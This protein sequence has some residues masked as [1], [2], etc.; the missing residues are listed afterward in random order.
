MIDNLY[1]ELEQKLAVRTVLHL[2]N[3]LRPCLAKAVKKKL[4][5]SNPA[6]DAD[7]P[8]PEDKN[9]A[10]VLDEDQLAALVRGFRGH[11][12]EMIVDVGANTGARRNEIIALCWSDLDLDKK[13]MTITRSVEETIKYGR[14]VKEPKTERGNRTISLDEPLVDRLRAYRRQMLRLVAGVPDGVD[15]N[16]GLI[17]LPPEACSS[18]A[19]RSRARTSI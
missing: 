12:L 10:N 4:I 13:T 17:K 5:V 11:A 3:C 15:V 1:I 19:S 2:H 6:D 8:S 16:L 7:A 14:H 18:P 9:I